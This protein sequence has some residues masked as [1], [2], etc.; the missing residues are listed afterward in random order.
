MVDS[1]GWLEFLADAPNRK[2]FEP[3]LLN[4]A[5]VIVPSITIYEVFR[6]ILRERDEDAAGEAAVLM[7]SGRVIDLDYSLAV[8][9]GYLGAQHKLPLADSVIYATARRHDAVLWTQ[10]AHFDGLPGVRFQ[11]KQRTR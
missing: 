1:S 9:A 5:E 3:L 8:S 2:F 4:P 11:P 7:R 6:K 10:D